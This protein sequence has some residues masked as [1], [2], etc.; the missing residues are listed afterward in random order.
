MKIRRLDGC[1]F[2]LY[3]FHADDVPARDLLIAAESWGGQQDRGQYNTDAFVCKDVL[4]L[5]CI[6]SSYLKFCYAQYS[7]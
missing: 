7:I 5:K 1:I 6:V 2:H 4:W 3:H